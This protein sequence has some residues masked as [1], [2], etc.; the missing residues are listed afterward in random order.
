MTACHS[1]ALRKLRNVHQ[2]LFDE[3]PRIVHDTNAYST[4][5]CVGSLGDCA[6]DGY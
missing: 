2:G 6:A 3:L 1:A 5:V 4:A